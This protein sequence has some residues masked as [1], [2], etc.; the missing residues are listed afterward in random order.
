MR[1]GGIKTRRDFQKRDQNDNKKIIA[2][3][4]EKMIP[5]ITKNMIAKNVI[6]NS[7]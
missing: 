1:G 7:W 3:K 2:Q 6:T 4:L 5:M